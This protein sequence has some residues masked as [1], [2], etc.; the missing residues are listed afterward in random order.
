MKAHATLAALGAAALCTTGAGAH[1]VGLSRGEYVVEGATVEAQVVFAR[2]ELIALVAGLDA[3][4]DGA[5]TSAEIGAGRDAIEGA[6]VARIKVNGD[7]AACPGTLDRV[8]LT[9]QDGVAVRAVYRCAERPRRL[10]VELAFL[11]DLSFGHRHLARVSAGSAAADRVLSQ[12]N[13][14]VALDVPAETSPRPARGDRRSAAPPLRRGALRVL[15]RHEGPAF[16]LALLASC[17]SR[18]AAI[19][20]AAAFVAAVAVGLDLGALGLF[21]PSPRVVEAALALSL[22][23]VGLETLGSPDGRRRFRV[24]VPFGV[25]HGLGCAAAF[26]AGGAPGELAAFGAGVALGLLVVIAAL[27]PATLWAR[28]QPAFQA[29]GLPVLGAVIA[30]AGVIGLAIG[31]T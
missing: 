6:L 27:V 2:K 11:D 15:T 17:S 14:S 16:L 26:D 3:D 23:Y 4:H 8:E 22:V 5:L 30:A 18:R 29:R 25:V 12:R 19:A 28:R 7:G 10:G 13:P 20:A 1:E 31:R 24:A 9:E 21:A